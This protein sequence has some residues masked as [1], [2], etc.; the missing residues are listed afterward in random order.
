MKQVKEILKLSWLEATSAIYDIG[1]RELKNI[2][3]V[4]MDTDACMNWLGLTHSKIQPS[5]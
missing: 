3:V 4:L 1:L 2:G 5:R